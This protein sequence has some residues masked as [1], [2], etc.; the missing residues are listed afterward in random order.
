MQFALNLTETHSEVWG[1]RIEVSEAIISEVTAIPQVEKAWF[2]RRVH[3]KHFYKRGSKFNH[4]EEGL[5]CN[6]CLGHGI[7]L[8]SSSKSTSL[9]KVGTKLFIIPTCLYFLISA[10]AFY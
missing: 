1:L 9:V 3:R 6:H 10:M 4:P 5:H 8:L 2:G 7:R